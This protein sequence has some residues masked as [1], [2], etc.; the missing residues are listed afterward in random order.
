MPSRT[1]PGLGLT[2]FWDLGASYKTGM[3]TNL[4]TLSALVQPTVISRT[5]SLPGSPAA[6]AR[7]IVPSGDANGNDIAIWDGPSGSEAWVYL[8]PAEGWRVYVEDQDYD[9]R[10]DGSAW[11]EV[12][13]GGGGSMTGAQIVSSLNAELGSSDWQTGDGSPAGTDVIFDPSYV[14]ADWS[15]DKSRATNDADAD[16][17]ESF[18]VSAGAV[19]AGTKVYFEVEVSGTLTGSHIGLVPG[20]NRDEYNTSGAGTEF[21]EFGVGLAPDGDLIDDGFTQAA[22]GVSF[23]DGDRLC[24]AYDGSTNEMWFAVNAAPNTA[25]AADW[26]VGAV[27]TGGTHVAVSLRNVGDSATVHGAATLQ[28]STPAGF[29]ALEDLAPVIDAVGVSEETGGGARTLTWADA[30]SILELGGASAWTVTIPDDATVSFPVGT[31]VNVTQSG[32]GTVT[33]QGDTGVSLNGV[34]AGSTDID[35]QWSGVSLYKRAADSWVIQ[36]SITGAVA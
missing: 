30:G 13:E 22:Q 27:F 33:I 25:G 12:Q 23:S 24:I 15:I 9:V 8:T 31:V 34:S 20:D 10:W 1:L 21:Y 4:Q 19:P 16:G 35:G 5:T 36:G 3:D 7:Y 26:P 11:Q 2:G 14:P 18:V 6:G 32:T 17:S 28:Y 29:T